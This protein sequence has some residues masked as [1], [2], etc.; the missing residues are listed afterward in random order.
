V[1][2]RCSPELVGWG[3]RSPLGTLSNLIGAGDGIEGDRAGAVPPAP[4]LKTS[5][6]L[7]QAAIAGTRMRSENT[8]SHDHSL[9]FALQSVKDSCSPPGDLLLLGQFRLLH[10]VCQVPTSQSDLIID[11]H[12]IDVR[13]GRCYL[14]SRN[15]IQLE[16]E[17]RLINE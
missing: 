11:S 3:R 16:L 7:T 13:F 15:M 9:V 2:D 8:G 6:G 1:E 12:A 17:W 4:R 14:L 5:F 10:D